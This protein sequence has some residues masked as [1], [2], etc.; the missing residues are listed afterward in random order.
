MGDTIIYIKVIYIYSLKK[1][2]EK[3]NKICKVSGQWNCMWL[4]L[5]PL[6][7]SVDIFSYEEEYFSYQEKN[8]TYLKMTQSHTQ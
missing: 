7:S 3:Y 5:S 6:E 2:S 1:T 4:L 8:I